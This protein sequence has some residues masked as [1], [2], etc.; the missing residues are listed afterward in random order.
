MPAVI[1][2]APVP[3]QPVRKPVPIRRKALSKAAK[4]HLPRWMVVRRHM[5]LTP[6]VTTKFVNEQLALVASE[7]AYVITEAK[8]ALAGI[9]APRLQSMG[10]AFIG[11]RITD[12]RNWVGDNLLLTLEAPMSGDALPKT[13]LRGGDV[14]E[15]DEPGGGKVMKIYDDVNDS[16]Y[17][18]GVI[19]SISRDRVVLVISSKE[20]IPTAWNGRLTIKMLVN[21]IPFRRTLNSLCDLIEMPHPRP[22]LHMVAFSNQLPKFVNPLLADAKMLDKSLNKSQRDAVRL[23]LAV[24]DIAMIHGPPGTGKTHTLLE[25]IRQLVGEGKRILV[26]GPSNVSVDNLVERLGKLRTIPIVRIGHPARILP[27]AAEFGIDH[28]ANNNHVDD[29]TYAVQQEIDGLVAQ[30]GQLSLNAERGHV[31]A[32]IRTLNKRR[33]TLRP[34]TAYQIIANARVV[35]STLSGAA[36]NKL[37]QNK[38]KF[39][40]VIIDESTQATEAECWIAAQKAP[41][42]ILAGDHQQLPPTIKSAGDPKQA[43]GQGSQLQFT[44][45]ERLRE[46]LGDRFCQMLTTQYRMHED[47]MKVSSERL[48]DGRLVADKSVATHVL[49]DLEHVVEN[50]DTKS[51]IAFIDTSGTELFESHEAAQGN[52]GDPSVPHAELGSLANKGEAEFAVEQVKRLIESGVPATDIAVISP[53]AGQVRLLKLMLRDRYPGVEIGSVD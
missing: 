38:A 40:V 35:L 16:D 28:L 51:P 3:V 7:R 8:K 10:H 17:L 23:A 11:L 12:S 42:L 4:A 1:A 15:I 9:P 44:M 45:F 21:D 53:Y 47:I 6:T 43:G 26:C 41:K 20:K 27:A 29:H 22:S 49:N 19:L 5:V 48:Y 37:A 31:C 24:K 25:I 34:R 46:K 18:S 14:V 50:V 36:S 52:P 32:K 33:Q 2:N 30:L 13:Q 39:D